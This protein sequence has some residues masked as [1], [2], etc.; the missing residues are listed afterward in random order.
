MWEIMSSEGLTD[1][2][3]PDRILKHVPDANT[4]LVEIGSCGSENGAVKKAKNNH[5]FHLTNQDKADIIDKHS[6]VQRL[7]SEKN[8]KKNES[9]SS[10]KLDE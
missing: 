1:P 7:S 2:S 10:K 9:F 6:K 3:D 4:N 5:Q 8:K